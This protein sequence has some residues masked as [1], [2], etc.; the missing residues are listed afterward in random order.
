MFYIRYVIHDQHILPNPGAHVCIYICIC[1]RKNMC[2]LVLPLTNLL[3][4]LAKRVDS[5]PQE[6]SQFGRDDGCD[7][8]GRWHL[9]LEVFHELQQLTREDGALQGL[10]R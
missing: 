1:S 4:F 9:R 2:I 8:R 7:R 5:V 10:R 6:L 3:V